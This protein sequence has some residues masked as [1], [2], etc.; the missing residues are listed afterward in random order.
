MCMKRT[1]RENL[2]DGDETWGLSGGCQRVVEGFVCLA[3]IDELVESD[4]EKKIESKGEKPKKRR[5]F[6]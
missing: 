3:M 1:K 4:G 5:T 6:Y 2:I